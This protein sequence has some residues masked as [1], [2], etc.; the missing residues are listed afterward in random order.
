VNARFAAVNSPSACLFKEEVFAAPAGSSEHLPLRVSDQCHEI[1][2]SLIL[3]RQRSP[4]VRVW[5]PLQVASSGR[6]SVEDRASR[7]GLVGP[8]LDIC[9][10]A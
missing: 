3:W 1:F 2:Q 7:P 4:L 9:G 5:D 8:V 6:Q 10:T